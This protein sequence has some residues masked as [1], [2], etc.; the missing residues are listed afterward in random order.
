MR[1]RRFPWV[2][3]CLVCAALGGI[4]EA[5]GVALGWWQLTQTGQVFVCSVLAVTASGAWAQ[6]SRRA[7]YEAQHS[8][9]ARARILAGIREAIN[10]GEIEVP[11]ELR[12]PRPGP[13]YAM[14]ERRR[15]RG[16]AVPGGRR[17]DDPPAPRRRPRGGPHDAQ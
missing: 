3:A 7:D 5:T 13:P 11:E 8:N 2:S 9:A 6:L 16:R 17:H 1:R 4:G 10:R 14:P 12:A 15:T